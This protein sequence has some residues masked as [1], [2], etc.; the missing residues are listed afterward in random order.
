MLFDTHAHLLSDAFDEDRRQVIECVEKEIGLC[1]EAAT[2]LVDS[3]QAQ[4]LSEKHDF[5]YC[6]AGIHPHEAAQAPAGYVSSLESLS[7][8]P[9]CRA[10]GE[11]GLD[12]HYDFSPRE[13]QRRVFAAQ[14]ELAVALEKPVIIHDR[15][16]HQDVYDLL[17]AHRGRL[18][19]VMHCYSGSWEMAK[20]FLDLG[21]YLSFAGPLTFK[22][23]H[24]LVE[25]AEQAPLDRVLCE[26]DSPYLTPVPLRGQRND[27]RNVRLVV[28]KLAQ[29]KRLPYPQIEQQTTQN[30]QA[31]FGIV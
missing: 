28:E 1:L 22:N 10:I 23:A 13:V 18:Y 31:L 26:T 2:T 7:R 30:G 11:I 20:R 29:C 27:P 15:E 12:Y 21:F 25:V 4:A 3:Q 6:A 17:S 16:A 8:H 19:G 14:L 9:K 24:K 5:L